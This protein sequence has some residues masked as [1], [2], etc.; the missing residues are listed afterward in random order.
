MA[1][2][3]RINDY[4]FME[5]PYR[6]VINAVTAKDATGYTAAADLE[7]EKGT[8]IVKKGAKISAADAK[9]LEARKDQKTWPVKAVVT[10]EI[11]FLDAADEE[12]AIIASAGEQIDDNG[13]FVS[14]RV[15]GRRHLVAAEVDSNDVN[16]IDAASRQ[17]IGSSAGLIP[18]IEKNYVYRSLMGSNQQRQ[19]VPLIK[20]EAPHVGTGMEG[21]AARNSGQVILAEEDGKVVEAHSGKVVVE[22]KKRKA[23][24]TPMHFLRSNEGSSINQKVVVS[25]GDKVSAGDILIE[26][27]SIDGGERA[28][29]IFGEI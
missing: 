27:M 11:E 25:T 7:D 15:S 22:Y 3:S 13:H 5:T 8:V 29:G 4:G 16:Y 17:I 24:Y 1:M 28:V 14:E 10:D 19:A 23:T 6:K 12:K 18:F 26:G 21:L 9:K 20:P 2:Y